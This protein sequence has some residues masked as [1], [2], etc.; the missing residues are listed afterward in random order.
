MQ[1]PGQEPLRSEFLVASFFCEPFRAQGA[2]QGMLPQRL[3]V[4]RHGPVLGTVLLALRD[5]SN[6]IRD[7]PGSQAHDRITYRGDLAQTTEEGGIRHTQDMAGEGLILNDHLRHL[8]DTI[9]LFGKDIHELE[10]HR[11]EHGQLQGLRADA[12]V[13]NIYQGLLSQHLGF[14][15]EPS[16]LA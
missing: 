16:Q 7:L 12:F 5:D 9:I 4:Y 11:M 13:N 6:D 1:E 10:R 14:S 3:H 15:Y 8:S 2:P